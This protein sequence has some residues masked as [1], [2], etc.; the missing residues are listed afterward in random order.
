MIINNLYIMRFVVR[1]AYTDA[2]RAITVYVPS[3]DFPGLAEGFKKWW[4]THQDPEASIGIGRTSLIPDAEIAFFVDFHE[5]DSAEEMDA[6]TWI[7]DEYTMYEIPVPT[8]ALILTMTIA[9]DD[10]VPRKVTLIVES[11]QVRDLKVAVEDWL[12]RTTEKLYDVHFGRNNK[13]GEEWF[14]ADCLDEGCYWD[15]KTK[16]PEST[17][18][19][20]QKHFQ[21]IDFN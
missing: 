5:C 14:F 15:G 11:S 17:Y 3:L 13:T 2:V 16:D 6:H 20:H 1:N 4:Y 9:R 21:P 18:Y 8:R 19:I 12:E 10:E 7:L